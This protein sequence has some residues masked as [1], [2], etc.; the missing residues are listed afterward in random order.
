MAYLNSDMYVN[1]A[2]RTAASALPVPLN[3]EHLDYWI[4]KVNG[5]MVRVKVEPKQGILLTPEESA[6]I[7]DFEAK[8]LEAYQEISGFR[9]RR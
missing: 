8:I 7:P 1:H 6:V 5:G 9:L 3:L 4:H 2:I